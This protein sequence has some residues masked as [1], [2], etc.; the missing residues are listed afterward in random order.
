ML[1]GFIGGEM[2]GEMV[3]FTLGMGMVIMMTMSWD[4]W[5][6]LD[7][8]YLFLFPFLWISLVL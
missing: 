4:I 5:V 3:G 2:G 8:F 1:G 6:F 7:L